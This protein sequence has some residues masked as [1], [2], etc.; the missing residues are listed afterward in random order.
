MHIKSTNCLIEISSGTGTQNQWI[1]IARLYWKTP[2]SRFSRSFTRSTTLISKRLNNVLLVLWA[3]PFLRMQTGNYSRS[4]AIVFHVFFFLVNKTCM[5]NASGGNL[6][7]GESCL[8]EIEIIHRFNW[9]GF[10]IELDAVGSFS[11]VC[12]SLCAVTVPTRPRPLSPPPH[13]RK[14]TRD[15]PNDTNI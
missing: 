10:P 14:K 4:F 3:T 5:L 9:L 11:V 1:D 13:P 6:G 8:F 7:K 2:K 15:T 12:A